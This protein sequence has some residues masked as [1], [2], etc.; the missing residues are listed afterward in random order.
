MTERSVWSMMVVVILP[1][2]H[3]LLQVVHRDELVRVHELV[4]Q[5]PVER[6]DQPIVGRL[7][8]PRVVELDAASIGPLV[9][10]FG[11]EL[12]AVV[13]DGDRAR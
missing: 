6:F 7:S 9:E 1:R 13:D 5:P 3:L 10:R 12:G 8:R 4:A 2:L 11:G